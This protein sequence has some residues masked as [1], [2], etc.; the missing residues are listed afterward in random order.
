[1]ILLSACFFL[2]LVLQLFSH[3]LQDAFLCLYQGPSRTVRM[4][5]VLLYCEYESF[6]TSGNFFH[7]FICALPPTRDTLIPGLTAGIMPEWNN[8]VSRNI[9]PSV[10]EITFVGIYAETSPACVSII[11]NAVSEPPPKSSDNLAAL[12]SNL[13]L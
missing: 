12:S 11:G 6:Q 10:I 7:C 8:S 5:E 4:L 13:E 9:C 1:M 2:A 3:P